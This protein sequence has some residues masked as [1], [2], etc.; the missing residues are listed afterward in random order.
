MR[1]NPATAAAFLLLIS[2]APACF[3]H[4]VTAVSGLTDLDTAKKTYR[5][6]LKMEVQPSGDPAIDDQISPEQAARALRGK[7]VLVLSGDADLRA[8]P[9][10]ARAIA[11]A[12]GAEVI[13]FPGARHGALLASDPLR[14]TAAL[15]TV[16]NA[17]R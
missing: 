6:E 1:L 2:L 5:V 16:I 13:T 3:A 15:D 11:A 7:R 8:R 4:K 10:E 9:K 17:L 14:Y 12:C